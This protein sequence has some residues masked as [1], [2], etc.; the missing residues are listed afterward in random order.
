[1]PQFQ[2]STLRA[3]SLHCAEGAAAPVAFAAAELQQYLQAMSGV[4]APV[5]PSAALT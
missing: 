3:A 5:V 2:L 4:R 1:M